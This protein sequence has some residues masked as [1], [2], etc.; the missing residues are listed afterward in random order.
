M[1]SAPPSRKTQNLTFRVT[2]EE[3]ALI[4]SAARVSGT[5]STQFVLGPALQHAREIAERKQVTVLT[6][7]SRKLFSAL[8]IDPPKPSK[9]FIR[10]MR[11]TRHE[12]VE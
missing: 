1:K 6:D 12:V 3:K 7:E 5:D 10:N 9:R 11:D 2:P 4:E 8:M